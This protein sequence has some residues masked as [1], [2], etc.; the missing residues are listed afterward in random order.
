MRQK[1]NKIPNT[2]DDGCRQKVSSNLSLQELLDLFP[3]V[4]LVSYDTKQY[5]MKKKLYGEKE[6]KSAVYR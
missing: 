1:I 4:I 5:E 2:S 6:N 3:R